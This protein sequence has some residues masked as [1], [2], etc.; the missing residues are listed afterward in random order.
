ML[1]EKCLGT[2]FEDTLIILFGFCEPVPGALTARVNVRALA[3]LALLEPLQIDEFAHRN[4]IIAETGLPV[5]T[6][7]SINIKIVGTTSPSSE[8]LL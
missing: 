3:L 1:I 2:L 4:L 7:V 5:A 8:E 6:S